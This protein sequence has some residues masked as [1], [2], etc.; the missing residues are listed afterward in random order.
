MIRPNANNLHTFEALENSIFFD[1]N[2]PNS[3]DSLDRKK[4]YFN[5]IDENQEK[6]DIS[7]KDHKIFDIEYYTGFAKIDIVDLPFKG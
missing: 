3:T 1:I 7:N 6:K 2:I 5:I 4:T